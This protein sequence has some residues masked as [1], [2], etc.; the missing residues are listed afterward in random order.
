MTELWRSEHV[1]YIIGVT[2]TSVWFVMLCNLLLG[3]EVTVGSFIVT[4]L[5]SF[6]TIA[7]TNQLWHKIL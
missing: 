2:A 3:N 1:F 7:V 5:I 4:T 6:V